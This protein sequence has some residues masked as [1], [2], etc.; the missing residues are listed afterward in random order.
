MKLLDLSP[1]EQL[2]LPSGR[3][4]DIN[5]HVDTKGIKYIGTAVEYMNGTWRAVAII[6]GALV[7]VECRV[8]FVSLDLES[9]RL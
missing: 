6:G 5:G 4:A 3:T 9:A 2:D 8:R 7:L 1:G